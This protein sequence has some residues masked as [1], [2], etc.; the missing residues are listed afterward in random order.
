MIN[1]CMVDY[2]VNGTSIN[3]TGDLLS[4][5]TQKM[6]C[7]KNEDE[8]LSLN[9]VS[10]EIAAP[11]MTWGLV[12]VGPTFS[13]CLF[14]PTTKTCKNGVEQS[15]SGKTALTFSK[16]AWSDFECQDCF[17]FGICIIKVAAMFH[18]LL[19]L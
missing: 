10:F 9:S 17:T 14:H 2:W 15:L 12:E 6:T 7:P 1:D 13:S 5:G 18:Q 19:P 4:L 3:K 8:V 11:F 16:R